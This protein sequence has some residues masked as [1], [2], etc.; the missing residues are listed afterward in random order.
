MPIDYF[1]PNRQTTKRNQM[2][3]ISKEELDRHLFL[4]GL[5][6]GKIA[7]YLTNEQK[8]Q[9]LNKLKEL[10]NATNKND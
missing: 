5:H 3:K 7:S 9:F 8:E 1:N 10:L 2:E 4:T 6:I